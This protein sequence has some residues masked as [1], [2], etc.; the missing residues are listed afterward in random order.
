MIFLQDFSEDGLV[1]KTEPSIWKYLWV[2]NLIFFSFK[3]YKNRIAIIKRIIYNKIGIIA[4]LYKFLTKLN[5][6]VFHPSPL[7]LKHFK[8]VIN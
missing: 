2:R 1:Y 6:I 8:N 3:N 5:R 7:F 4:K